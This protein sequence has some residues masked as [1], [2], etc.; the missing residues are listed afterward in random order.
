MRR[1]DGLRQ[2]SR[3]RASDWLLFDGGPVRLPLGWPALWWSGGAGAF[4]L[5]RRGHAGCGRSGVGGNGAARCFRGRTGRPITQAPRHY[6]DDHVG[7]IL[8]P[9]QQRAAAL[10]ELLAAPVAAETLV[11]MG[12]ALGSLSDCRG[13]ALDTPRPAATLS[14]TVRLYRRQPT[15]LIA[16]GARSDVAV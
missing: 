14:L 3:R 9:V 6:E 12:G 10:V 5:D 11:A 2:H 16:A 7:R 13:P 15:L 8:R 1:F 4:S